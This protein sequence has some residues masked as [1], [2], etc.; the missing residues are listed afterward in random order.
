M[1][2]QEMRR[3]ELC[4]IEKSVSGQCMN[5]NVRRAILALMADWERQEG[6]LRRAQVERLVLR[7][8]LSA[9]ETVEVFRGLAQAGISLEDDIDAVSSVD[10]HA[11]DSRSRTSRRESADAFVRG[12][13]S[14]RRL[15]HHEEIELGRAV[16]IGRL[17]TAELESCTESEG[18]LE[19]AAEGERAR[20]RLV[21]ANLRLVFSV[22]RKLHGPGTLELSDLVQEGTIGL[23]RAADL[24]DPDLGLKFSTY[25]T[26]WIRQAIFRSCD[27][28]LGLIRLPVHRLDSIRKLRRARR[29]LNV[30]LGRSPKMCELAEALDWSPEKIAYL[31]AVSRLHIVSFDSPLES[32]DARAVGD[33]IGSA[34]LNPE[35]LC[36]QS[37]RLR[38]VHRLVNGLAPRQRMVVVRRFGLI[39]GRE[40]T[41]QQIG[42]GLEVT[43]ERI[44]QIEVKALQRL[45]PKA[46][47]V[48]LPWD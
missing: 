15:A 44:R 22:A 24:F 37:E 48:Q 14:V 3:A 42:D 43:R 20:T 5:D 32:D 23:M 2:L 4:P 34:G 17:A 7:R 28:S 36:L 21:E 9:E 27:N 6:T 39:D 41:L 18:L 8:S 35:Q 33:T 16:Q 31:Q 29:T 10:H 45:G 1:A 26:H 25:A 19:L 38:L 46:R 11:Q 40:E 12:Y 13:F 47:V 30:E